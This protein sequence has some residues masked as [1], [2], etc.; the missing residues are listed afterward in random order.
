VPIEQHQLRHKY[1][2]AI[3][4]ISKLSVIQ[5]DKYLPF[6][7]VDLSDRRRHRVQSTIRPHTEKQ[8][9][10]TTAD[11]LNQLDIQGE[12]HQLSL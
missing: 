9:D 2:T 6:A 7:I 4:F 11:N 3:T 1:V 5:M 8:M 12:N 10:V